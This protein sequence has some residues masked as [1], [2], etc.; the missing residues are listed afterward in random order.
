MA[1]NG[2]ILPGYKDSISDTRA[3]QR[4]E[5]KLRLISG[6]DPYEI[7]REAWKDDVDPWPKTTYNYLGMY[8]VFSPSPYTGQIYLTTKALNATKGL[9]LDG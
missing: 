9:L 3:R 4:Y 2:A 6:R 1:S 5:E 7:P 8:S